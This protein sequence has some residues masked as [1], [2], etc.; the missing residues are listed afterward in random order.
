MNIYSECFNIIINGTPIKKRTITKWKGTIPEFFASNTHFLEEF[1]NNSKIQKKN[2]ILRE[3]EKQTIEIKN[4][5]QV[6][7]SK[8]TKLYEKEIL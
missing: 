5:V 2:E 1:N 7:I 4:K 8:I 3:I 6:I